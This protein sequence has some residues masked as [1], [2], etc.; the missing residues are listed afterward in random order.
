VGSGRRHRSNRRLRGRDTAVGP[1][2][3]ELPSA[4]AWCCRCTSPPR[5][6]SQSS[7]HASPPI[8]RPEEDEEPR[9]SR[10]SRGRRE[11]GRP[12]PW[13]K[14]TSVSIAKGGGGR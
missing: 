7:S 10:W 4:P 3:A 9:A 14:P 11:E 1:C 2:S 13:R 5:E 6:L 8:E 12:M